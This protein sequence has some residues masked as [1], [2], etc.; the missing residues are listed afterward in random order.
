MFAAIF[1]I[2]SLQFASKANCAK[3]LGVFIWQSL[4]HHA[5]FQVLWKE[6][7]LRGHQVTI[8]TPHPLNDPA[9]TNLTE[10]DLGLLQQEDKNDSKYRLKLHKSII[11]VTKT[12]YE[13][14]ETLTEQQLQKSAIQNFLRDDS[15]AFDLLLV[16]FL[17]PAVYAISVKYNCPMIGVTSLDA[18]T[19]SH[20]AV[21]N[22]LHPVLSPDLLL[23]FKS[24]EL[25][26]FDRLHSVSFAVWYR[27]YYYWYVLPQHDR[28]ARKYIQ[29]NIPYIGDIE[30]NVSMLF[31]NTSP[32]IHALRPNV[33]TIIEMGN[34]HLKPKKLLPQVSFIILMEE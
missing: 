30:R 23:P 3:I 4:S 31:I 14:M 27:F 10:I 2:F 1:L 21:G 19:P 5:V 7:S 20:D 12:I 34:I 13:K 22:I 8:L 29:Q 15:K 16:E 11:N 26:F 24:T 17:V 18:L 6:L 25:N 33:K 32:F 28:L 9:L